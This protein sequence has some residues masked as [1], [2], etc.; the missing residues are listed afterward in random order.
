[1]NVPKAH[2]AFAVGFALI[3]SVCH[4]EG[5]PY[6]E[7]EE[8]VRQCDN[9]GR[10]FF[11]IAGTETCLRVSGLARSDARYEDDAEDRE[12]DNVQTD[13][14]GRFI[15]DA[16]TLT[17]WDTLRSVFE[18][19]GRWDTSSTDYPD[20]E[21]SNTTRQAYIELAGITAGHLKSFYDLTPYKSIADLFSDERVTTLAYTFEP[22]EGVEATVGVEDKYYRASPNDGLNSE[23]DET[24]PNAIATL[25][26][27]GDW[28]ETNLS[29]ALQDNEGDRDIGVH[30]DAI[31]WAAQ[32]N[33]VVDLPAE[34]KGSRI[35][36]Q[37]VYASGASSYAGGEDFRTN[38]ISANFGSRT[39]RDQRS[40]GAGN[41]LNTD[42][43][44]AG[45]GIRWFWTDEVQSN[46]SAI[47][48]NVEPAV[49]EFAA[50]DYVFVEANTFWNPAPN[51]ELG[52]ALQYGQASI[53]SPGDDAPDSGAHWAVV[54]RLG[55]SF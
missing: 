55:R 24:W 7:P 4:A 42:I 14:R 13:L 38:F 6:A 19:E 26:W 35:W 25:Q 11:N 53:L 17:E 28:G 48:S 33:L 46:L 18:F 9:Y 8:F 50:Y 37:G 20:G 43:W 15:L 39:V 54:S 47:Y 30:G 23:L 51:L 44:S 3:A 21:A 32:A 16:R 12:S 27:K 52:L 29:V 5:L 10:G 40:D 1:M 22:G 49:S 36:L 2:A 41:L 45:G 31:G 34:V